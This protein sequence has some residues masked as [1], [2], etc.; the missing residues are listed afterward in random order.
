MRCKRV[1][2]ALRGNPKLQRAGALH[3]SQSQP[4]SS[5]T[6]CVC[7]VSFIH[8]R[9]DGH[10]LPQRST[11]VRDSTASRANAQARALGGTCSR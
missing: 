2:L 5:E 8:P 6:V 11:R 3:D 1:L 7:V 9:V 10:T 4:A